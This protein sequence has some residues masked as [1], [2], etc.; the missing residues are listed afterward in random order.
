MEFYSFLL[1]PHPQ[2]IRPSCKALNILLLDPGPVHDR[3]LATHEVKGIYGEY[4]YLLRKG[5]SVHFVSRFEEV[6]ALV[7]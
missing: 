3:R 5:I 7:F 6:V 1:P 2:F 4:P